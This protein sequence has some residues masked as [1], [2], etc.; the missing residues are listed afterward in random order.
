MP[1]ADDLKL[2]TT[3][4]EKVPWQAVV[5]LMLAREVARFLEA[6]RFDLKRIA[7]AMTDM[8]S[9]RQRRVWSQE[10]RDQWQSKPTD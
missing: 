3:L 8:V 1:S 4:L 6:V 2:W 7:D 5:L 10:E 9:G